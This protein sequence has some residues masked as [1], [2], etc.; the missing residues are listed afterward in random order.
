MHQGPALPGWLFL[1]SS[2]T[3]LAWQAVAFVRL[4]FPVNEATTFLYK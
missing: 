2:C 3:G 4:L 1:I